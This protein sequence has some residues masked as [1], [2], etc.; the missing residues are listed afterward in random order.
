M[1]IS[2]VSTKKMSLNNEYS[3]YWIDGHTDE[4]GKWCNGRVQLNRNNKV[5]YNNQIER[6]FKCNVS[7]NGVVICD[8]STKNSLD[9][10]KKIKSRLFCF[11]SRGFIMFKK[12]FS[13]NIGDIFMIDPNGEIAIV[14]TLYSDTNHSNKIFVFNLLNGKI[15]DQVEKNEIIST[16]ID[17]TNRKVICILV[18]N[19]SIEIKY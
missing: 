3:I 15:I 5:V 9:Y 17:E 12:Q 16:K 7:N 13:A 11:D 2:I 6:P 1:D 19:D 18:D 14:D 4:K 8:D 10:T